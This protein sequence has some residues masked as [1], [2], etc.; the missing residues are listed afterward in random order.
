MLSRARFGDDITESDNE[1]VSEDY[2]AS[3]HICRVHVIREFREEEYEG[4]TLMI[5]KMLQEVEDSTN[6]KGR[7]AEI[8]RKKRQVQKFFLENGLLWR[9]PKRPDGIPLRV[10]GKKEQRNRIM[11]EFHESDW[12]GHRGTWA[13]FVKIKQKY[14]WKSMYKDIAEFTESCEKCQ[15]YSGVRHRDELHPTF[16]PTINFK[17][18]VDIVAMPTRIGQRK[19]LV[20]ARNDLTNQVEGWALRRKTCST[21]CQFLL[22]E[23]FCRYGCLGQLIADR[24]ELDSDKHGDSL[25]NMEFGQH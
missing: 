13:T 22:E 14:W 8:R 11:S 19:Y 21:V 6:D 2:F 17:W 15:V 12:A 7:R 23:V 4:E 9:A 16:S 5:G 18:M 20:L 3:E 24:G 1:E 25:P 10:V